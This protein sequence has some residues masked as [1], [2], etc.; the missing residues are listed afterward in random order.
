MDLSVREE[1]LSSPHYRAKHVA[2]AVLV[3]AVV[4]IGIAVSAL[5]SQR[6]E[7]GIWVLLGVVLVL[8]ITV[9]FRMN[10]LFRQPYRVVLRQDTL[11]L[12]RGL[13]FKD[14]PLSR[15]KYV[16]HDFPGRGPRRVILSIE[17]DSSSDRVLEIVE[18]VPCGGE[19]GLGGKE[20]ADALRRRAEA[21]RSVG[22]EQ[23]G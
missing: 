11:R 23:P 5:R 15:I 14:I 6:Q 2:F 1:E 12:Y 22:P 17:P 9:G 20:V 21:A 8:W 7:L 3:W 10:G 4:T 16:E 13:G 18:F 19:M